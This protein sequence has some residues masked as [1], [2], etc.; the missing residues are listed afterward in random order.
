MQLKNYYLDL[1]K[2][3]KLSKRVQDRIDRYYQDMLHCNNDGRTDMAMSFFNT[4]SQAG[5]LRELRSEKISKI[6]DESN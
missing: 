1:Q 4:L 6:L 3:S 2:V 5:Y